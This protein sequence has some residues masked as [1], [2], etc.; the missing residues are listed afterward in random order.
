MN[1]I[2]KIAMK[3]VKFIIILMNLIIINVL[4]IM[5]VHKNSIN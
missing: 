5:N 2:V 4:K 1:L 3:S